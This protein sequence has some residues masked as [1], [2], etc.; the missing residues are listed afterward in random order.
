MTLIRF[1]ECLSKNIVEAM[2]ALGLPEGVAVEHPNDHGEGTL[3]DVEWL[4]RFKKAGGR[5]IV[6]G[7][8]KM[9]GRIAERMALQAA[10]F[11]A[12]FPPSKGGY[13]SKL[14]KHGQAA[15]L[16]RWLHEIARL[17]AE[18]ADGDHFLLPPSFDPDPAKII[19]LHRLRGPTVEEVAAQKRGAD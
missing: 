14:R 18:A 15:Y 4:P 17:A 6:T 11:V 9:R 2:R 16:I 10:D 3:A 5:C 13:Y 8:P 12:I 19:K 1:D 7:D